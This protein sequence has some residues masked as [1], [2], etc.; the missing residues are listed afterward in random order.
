MP[1]D[2]PAIQPGHVLPPSVPSLHVCFDGTRDGSSEIEGGEHKVEG[3]SKDEVGGG[4]PGE[5]DGDGG[6]PDAG[7]GG[8]FGVG[9]HLAIEV[10]D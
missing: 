3:P 6:Q 5:F 1:R 9:E 4:M 7:V 10:L 8:D 2:P